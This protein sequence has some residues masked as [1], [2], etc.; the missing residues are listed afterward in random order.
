MSADA[1]RRIEDKC[2]DDVHERERAAMG[3]RDVDLR[4]FRQACFA[5]IKQLEGLHENTNNEE[6]E[7]GRIDLINT[8]EGVLEDTDCDQGMIGH[9]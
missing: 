8:L 7:Q 4:P 1:R 2:K 3:P 5:L 9:F 6:E